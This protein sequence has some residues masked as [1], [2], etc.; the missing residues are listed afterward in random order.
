MRVKCFI[1]VWCLAWLQPRLSQAGGQPSVYSG[2][3]AYNE[4]DLSTATKQQTITNFVADAGKDVSIINV[5]FSWASGSSTNPSSSFPATGMSF[6][7]SHGSLPLLTWEPWN[8]ALGTTQSFTLAN[9]MNGVY[10]SYITNWA[11]DAKG[12]GQPFFLRLGHEMNGNWYPWCA[13]VNGNTP[14]QYVQMWRHVHD[15]FTRVGATN[16]TWVWC[17]NT[18]YSTSTPIDEL[19]PGDNYADWIAVDGYNRLANSWQDFSTLAQPTLTQLTNI[20]PGKPI[21][22]AESGCNQNTNYDKSQWFLNALTNCLPS[23]QPRIKAW[24]YFNSTNT[25]DGNDW[26]IE[27][28]TN[29][30][31]G[32]QQ[33]IAPSYFASNQF[34]ANSATPIQPLNNDAL[35]SDTMA[36]FVS[37]VSPPTN[38]FTSGAAVDFLALA[39][40]KSGISNV[41]FSINGVPL[42]TNTAAPYRFSWE[43]PAGTQSSTV[44]ATALDNAGNSAASTVQLF[45]TTYNT[46]TLIAPDA[47]GSSSFNAAGN[48]DS[49]SSPS[50]GFNYLVG[51]GCTLLT[52]TNNSPCTFAGDW[53]TVAGTLGFKATNTITVPILLL[54]NGVIQN[55]NTRGT[56]DAG[57]L[58]GS[59]TVV[60][61][62]TID[63]GG[64]AGDMTSMQILSAIGGGG[65]LTVQKPQTVTLCG[66][67]TFNGVL[68]LRGATLQLAAT[69]SMAPSSLVMQSFAQAGVL[70]NLGV[71]NAVLAG[72]SLNVGYGPA[73]VLRVGY[74]DSS[75]YGNNCVAMLDVSSQPQFS[76]DV[77]EFSVG[78]NT[79]NNDSCTTVGSVLLATNNNIIATNV[80]FGFSAF[81]GGG[82]NSV[83]L[84]GGSN[85]FN[86][87]A[88]TIGGQK[89]NAQLTLPAGGVL[90][91]DNGSAR[92]DLAVAGQDFSTSVTCGGVADLSAGT[93]IASLGSLSVGQKSGG[94]VGGATGTLIV[95]GA[96]ANNINV[97]SLVIGSLLGAT[98]G[99]PIAQGTLTF[100]GGVFLV[101]SNVTLGALGGSYGSAAGA[102]NI[103]GGWFGVAGNIVDGGGSSALNVNGGVIDLRPM[104][105]SDTGS[106]SV[107]TLL[108]NGTISNVQNVTVAS[109]SGSGVIA[110]QSGLTSVSNSTTPG[111]S[112][113]IGTLS[114]GALGLSGSTV[115]E[116]NRASSPN[117]DR[118][119]AN[120]IGLGG[121]LTVANL[122][123]ALQ[124]GDS[125]QLFS[126][127]ISGKFATTNLPPLSSTNLVWDTSR[128]NSEGILAVTTLAPT[129]SASWKGSNLVVQV[130]SV[131][132]LAYVL[133]ATPQLAP[134]NWT[135]I[136]TNPGGGLLSYTIPA[137]S[138][139][140]FFRICAQ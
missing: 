60:T 35:A 110:N 68:T 84:G 44:T 45:A 8:P 126:G 111:G 28:P 99:S 56:P 62:G 93:F 50:P 66:T 6:I 121:T 131:I 103:N 14:S 85:Y 47:P 65:D 123:P 49:G 130:G 89:E 21:M 137:G 22:V 77:G 16:V 10:D 51:P 116:L 128:L 115:M 140:Q 39:T 64:N 33:G 87:A 117:A 26:R 12:W 119:A 36:P 43:V 3:F 40:D 75:G 135:A 139:Q 105:G 80:L 132:G 83:R 27:V 120:S 94:N 13:S 19:Y 90:R 112:N 42:Q 106:I 88:M 58:A 15:L 23:G 79:V 29:A 124:A 30:M 57:Y 31:A 74:R 101:N 9:I 5:F 32:Y 63:A 2:V 118:L 107:D 70:T 129:L 38:Q 125:F 134:A 97:N 91:L 67:N 81:T 100:G 37:I 92:T 41:V 104:A 69:A 4:G 7:R 72:G 55:L 46:V 96:P 34:G 98:S 102:L 11:M 18:L 25:S 127:A 73:G 53:L 86:T 24:V 54:S 133:E 48:W 109:L 95:S 113:S 82:T 71:T 61:N 122:G 1:L 20:A 78:N 136:Q 59:L 114:M 108:L 138:G 52:P 76:A 17:V